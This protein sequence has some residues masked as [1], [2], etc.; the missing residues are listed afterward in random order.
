MS[1]T[2]LKHLIYFSFAFSFLTLWPSETAAQE[3]TV[4]DASRAE[5]AA[6][7][8]IRGRRDGDAIC[9]G[10]LIT[11]DKVLT[12]AHC[13]THPV[14]GKI[15]PSHNINFVAGWHHGEHH[16]WSIA[17]KVQ[18]HP[19]YRNG[20]NA[21]L[22]STNSANFAVDLALI[23]LRSPVED[24]APSSIAVSSEFAGPAAVLGYQ[25]QN[26]DALIDYVGCQARSIDDAFLALS[27][28]VKSGTSGG[29]VFAL[30]GGTW[31]LTGVVVG[32][33][34]GNNSPIKGLA[35][36]I[37]TDRLLTIFE[38]QSTSN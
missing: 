24:V 27:C 2:P 8:Q 6:I 20:R 34:N 36:R 23:T 7:G 15:R 11:P 31:Q 35:V 25:N 3:L 17:R 14:T 13:V 9:T 30:E 19:D 22:K 38:E 5:W 33:V 26:R 12:A 29:P 37:D 28:G 16:G 18:V 1:G 32:A 10:T 21:R 4:T